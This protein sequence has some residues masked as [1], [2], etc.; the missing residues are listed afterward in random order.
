MESYGHS[1]PPPAPVTTGAKTTSLSSGDAQSTFGLQL[2]EGLEPIGVLARFMESM[3]SS[4]E[5]VGLGRAL[6][7]PTGGLSVLRRT[8]TRRVWSA[9]S[10][11]IPNAPPE[12]AFSP[13][14]MRQG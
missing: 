8:R 1:S 3:L 5:P 2:R 12:Y 9:W 6:I 7:L 14:G 10:R 13:G 4:F 11:I